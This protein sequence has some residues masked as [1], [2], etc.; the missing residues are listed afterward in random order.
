[1]T[2]M[3]LAHRVPATLC[4]CIRSHS[5]PTPP[6]GAA[7]PT[8]GDTACL[9][10]SYRQRLF[11]LVHPAVRALARLVHPTGA[12]WTPILAMPF[13]EATAQG[14]LGLPIP[15]EVSN[16]RAVDAKA[17]AELGASVWQQTA[18]HLLEVDGCDG[19]SGSDEEGA[20]SLVAA[21]G[22]DSG[23]GHR[24]IGEA[25]NSAIGVLCRI[26]CDAGDLSCGSATS[27]GPEGVSTPPALGHSVGS[28]D[29]PGT[30]QG[31][32]IAALRVLL[33][34]CRASFD[35]AHAVAAFDG[36]ATVQAL[37]DRLCSPAHAKEAA[38]DESVR[39]P[40][41]E[42]TISRRI[43]LGLAADRRCLNRV[44]SNKYSWVPRFPSLEIWKY[45]NIVSGFV[46]IL[47]SN[48]LY[49]LCCTWYAVIT[50]S[51][52]HPACPRQKYKLTTPSLYYRYIGRCQV[53]RT[54]NPRRRFPHTSPSSYLARSV[55]GTARIA[56]ATPRGRC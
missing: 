36:G 40:K 43:L 33:H 44:S 29:R 53:H 2:G 20:V 41:T 50:V 31:V 18:K 39:R 26:L 6:L 21:M 55:A 37:L 42:I 28:E 8:R 38:A 13:H 34:V 27:G 32:Q 51:H 30:S 23:R 12:Q 56:G 54:T 3:L 11:A 9:A 49:V 24:G 25:D 47:A 4:A 35:V 5:C 48:A 1:M 10:P 16:G 45:M 19:S 15:V 22:A 46:M 7:T 17:A 14:R 52:L